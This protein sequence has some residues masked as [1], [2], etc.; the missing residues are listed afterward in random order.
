MDAASPALYLSIG[1]TDMAKK[2]K[3]S[4]SVLI[5]RQISRFDKKTEIGVFLQQESENSATGNMVQALI[6]R[7]D[8]HPSGAVK[9]G[10]DKAICNTCKHMLQPD[11]SRSCYCNVLFIAGGIWNAYKRGNIDRVDLNTASELCRGRAVRLGSYGDPAA[12][13]PSVWKRLLSH[14]TRHT[15]YTHNWKH[16][17][18]SLKRTVMAS[19]D[20]PAEYWAALDKGWRTYRVRRPDEPLLP[21]EISCPKSAEAGKRTTCLKCTLCDGK[22]GIDDN[23]KNLAIIA[24]GPGTSAF[25]TLSS[26]LATN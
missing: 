24:H 6:I 9:N 3:L 15:G 26:L 20:S 5:H 19:V 23:R 21:Y 2:I 22:K 12:I 8:I 4:N 13:D 16:E 11:G 18:N 25:I 17:R 14:S 1:G 10:M 7:L